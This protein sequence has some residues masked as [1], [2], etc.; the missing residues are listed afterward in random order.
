M[1]R[2]A[3]FIA[4]RDGQGPRCCMDAGKQT[5]KLLTACSHRRALPMRRLPASQLSAQEDEPHKSMRVTRPQTPRAQQWRAALVL[6]SDV[7]NYEDLP[8]VG[9]PAFT[10]P[11][12]HGTAREQ[13]AHVAQHV[14]RFHLLASPHM[15]AARLQGVFEARRPSHGLVRP[16]APG[17][18]GSQSREDSRAPAPVRDGLD[19][20]AHL[21]AGA[22]EVLAP[23][24]PPARVHSSVLT[25]FTSQRRLR[26]PLP[27]PQPTRPRPSPR[28][29]P[30]A[31]VP[32]WAAAAP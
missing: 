10:L 20:G 6:P 2:M 23:P 16:W 22:V 28:R 7:H 25:A 1:S 24:A 26:A 11:D 32:A 19:L 18:P 9:P 27:F 29:A 8:G 14:R 13:Q 17:G 21:V 3:R 4:G 12:M 31:C 30:G 5:W 15:Q